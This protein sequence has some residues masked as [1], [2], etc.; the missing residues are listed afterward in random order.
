MFGACLCQF[1]AIAVTNL[2]ASGLV[3][4]GSTAVL[5]IRPRRHRADKART[6]HQKSWDSIQAGLKPE[7]P[8][9]PLMVWRAYGEKASPS[10]FVAV[11]TS[12]L[13]KQALFLS[14]LRWLPLLI[15][16]C[17]ATLARWGLGWGCP[18]S[19]CLSLL[20]RPLNR[21]GGSWHGLLLIVLPRYGVTRLIAV[22]LAL[23]RALLFHW[24]ISIA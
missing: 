24:R 15:L 18:R 3:I 11:L 6:G 2:H 1:I 20:R 17:R 7:L 9:R 4:F 19:L 8:L 10:L 12:F 22:I 13:I 5:K 21:R 23:Q 14:P 16:D